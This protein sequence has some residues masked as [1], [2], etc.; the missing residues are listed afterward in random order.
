MKQKKM[1]KVVDEMIAENADVT[2]EVCLM[3][4]IKEG[5]KATTAMAAI[6][7]AFKAAG[8]VT[9]TSNTAL[10]ECRDYIKELDMAEYPSFR[11]V[12]ILSEDMQ[13]KFSINDDDDKGA[14]SALKVIRAA[15]KDAELAMP[16]KIHLGTVKEAMID[17]FLNADEDDEPTSVEAL[18][19]YLIDTCLPE[20]RT[21]ESEKR[22]KITAGTDYNFAML[23]INGQRLNEVN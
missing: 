18:T 19:E 12:R 16:K 1:I 21:K 11:E 7:K 13:S 23:L 2:R 8:I 3:A 15:F 6:T 17:Y 20:E 9:T 22:M 5:G 14:A 4:L 10:K